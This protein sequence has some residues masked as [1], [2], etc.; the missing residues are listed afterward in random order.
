VLAF[1]AHTALA[2]FLWTRL[3]PVYLPRG[4][5]ILAA[6]A[7]VLAVVGYPLVKQIATSDNMEQAIDRFETRVEPAVPWQMI[8]AYR[9]YTEQLDNMQGMLTSAS[10]KP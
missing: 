4:Q 2:V 1:I 10:R 6:T 9:R 7:I 8:V 3:R 5:S